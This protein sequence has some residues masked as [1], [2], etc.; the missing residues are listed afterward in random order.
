MEKTALQK[1][2]NAEKMADDIIADGV[3][4][5]RE[6]SEKSALKI[7]ALNTEF[8]EQLDTE[9]RKIIDKKIKDAEKDAIKVEASF[10]AECIK[11]KEQASGN[12]DKAVDYVVEKVR[13]GR[14]Q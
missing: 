14:W 12:I 9:V 6:I 1:I 2:L 11:I 7:R 5:S 3:R 13:S 4:K 8:E 10:D